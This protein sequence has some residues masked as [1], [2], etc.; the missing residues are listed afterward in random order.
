[1]TRVL[2]L[3]CSPGAGGKTKTALEAVLE[4]AVEAGATTSLVEL[5]DHGAQLAEVVDS[6]GDAEAFVFGSP[7]YRATFA[8]PFKALLDQTPRGMYGEEKAPLMAHAAL[9]VATAASD[10]HFLGPAA[11]R[12]VLVD[13][14]AAHV[15]S[16]GLYVPAPGFDEGG[17]LS[18][19][20]AE[21][22]RLQ[23]RALVE[24][25]EAI[26]A[27]ESLRAVTPNA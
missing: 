7:M 8:T 2:A 20:Y 25:A 14:F 9:T 6:L 27:S 23:G 4:G 10:H 13:F 17:A 18:A 12:D 26:A 19:E 16:P 11:M 15:V 22:A 3:N 5:A 21:R 1:M 24:L